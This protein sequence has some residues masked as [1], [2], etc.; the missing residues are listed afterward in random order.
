M[1]LAG[2]TIKERQQISVE[3]PGSIWSLG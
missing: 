2:Y 1:V 3:N